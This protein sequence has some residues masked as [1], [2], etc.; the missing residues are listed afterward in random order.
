M[1]GKYIYIPKKKNKPKNKKFKGIFKEIISLKRNIN[2]EV[3]IPWFF[4]INWYFFFVGNYFFYG[5]LF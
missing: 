2:K 1:F 3:R 4:V 5:L